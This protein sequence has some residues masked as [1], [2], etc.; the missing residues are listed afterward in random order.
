MTEL[1][2][3]TY[4]YKWRDA[5]KEHHKANQRK[6]QKKYDVFKREQKI[7]LNILIDG[8]KLHFKFHFKFYFY[9]HFKFIYI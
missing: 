4:I 5:N 8:F 7:F 6:Y 3:N 9:F 1:K 2:N